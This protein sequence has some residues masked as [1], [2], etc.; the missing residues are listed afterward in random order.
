MNNTPT[1]SSEKIEVSA[2]DFDRFFDHLIGT[3]QTPAGESL[4]DL[5]SAQSGGWLDNDS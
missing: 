4:T 1:T 5:V 2:G 3:P